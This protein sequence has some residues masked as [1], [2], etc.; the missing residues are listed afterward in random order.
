MIIDVPHFAHEW[1][2]D[3]EKLFMAFMYK[4]GEEHGFEHR[5]TVYSQDV[6][7]ITQRYFLLPQE[8]YG[9]GW[10]SY[11][12]GKVNTSSWVFQWKK[13][14]IVMPY[15]FKGDRANLIW[16]YLEGRA[17]EEKLVADEYTGYHQGRVDSVLTT[18][19]LRQFKYYKQHDKKTDEG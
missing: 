3:Y 13:K 5:Y 1:E 14:P 9:K 18:R 8:V 15:E 12:F 6:R 2:D 16:G 10:K 17:A 4:I 19:Q 7:Y 11:L